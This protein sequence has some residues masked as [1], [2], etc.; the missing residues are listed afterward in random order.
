M[1]EAL[2]QLN[3][4]QTVERHLDSI[5]QDKNNI[6]NER[7][8]I[9]QE[10]AELETKI[11]QLQTQG[12][13]D[14]LNL[15][16]TEIENLNNEAKYAT[17]HLQKPFIKMQAMATSGGGGGVTPDELTKITQYLDKPFDALVEE[18]TGY[19]V[20]R[21]ILEKLEVMLDKDT[22]KI[23]DDKA[24][25][26]QESANEMLRQ[27][28]LDTLQVRCKAMAT[29]RDQLMVSAKLDEINRDIAQYQEQLVQLRARK[30]SVET[31]ESVKASSYQ[32]TGER[33]SSLK[34]S[35]EK[36]ILAALGKKIQIA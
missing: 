18:K 6:K 25:K 27:N 34:R 22:L 32:E 21:E 7:V 28:V 35:V 8:P 31:H 9:E 10:I 4:L 26:A 23:K 24:R 36:N 29:N 30:T 2:Q 13:I 14:K 33:I 20:L 1:E 17:R 15:I 5:Q 19:P 3:E 16:N 11:N 12:P